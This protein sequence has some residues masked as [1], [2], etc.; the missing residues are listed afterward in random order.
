[1]V[2]EVSLMTASSDCTEYF[3]H[4]RLYLA[5]GM[6]PSSYKSSVANGGQIQLSSVGI[7]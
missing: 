4:S 5:D 7:A 1:V 3:K 2:Q 6:K